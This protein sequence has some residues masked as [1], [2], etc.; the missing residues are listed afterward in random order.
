MFKKWA[1][2]Q[3]HLE[4][5]VRNLKANSAGEDEMIPERAPL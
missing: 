4:A 1:S 3:T 2:T 5:L